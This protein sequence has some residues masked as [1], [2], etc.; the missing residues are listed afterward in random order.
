MAYLN[1]TADEIFLDLID[2]YAKDGIPRR[3]PLEKK[4]REKHHLSP[5]EVMHCFRLIEKNYKDELVSMCYRSFSR[6]NL[7]PKYP[8]DSCFHNSHNRRTR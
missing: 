7:S 5:K 2:I 3:A 1:P 6:W 8:T 4:M